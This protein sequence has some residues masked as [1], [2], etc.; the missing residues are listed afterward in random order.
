VLLLNRSAT[1]S[2]LIQ[3]AE[4]K[5]LYATAGIETNQT[6]PPED[7]TAGGRGVAWGGGGQDQIT[8]GGNAVTAVG[9][10]RVAATDTFSV[11]VRAQAVITVNAGLTAGD[12][13]TI[14][15][16]D[17]SAQASVTLTCVVGPRVPGSLTFDAAV[18]AAAQAVNI[19]TAINDSIISSP[20]GPQQIATSTVLL[21][22]VTLTAGVRVSLRGANG[23]APVRKNG[24]ATTSSLFPQVWVGTQL[25]ATTATAGALTLGQFT[26]GVNADGAQ[27]YDDNNAPGGPYY[28]R[29]ISYTQNIA[30]A[31]N[32]APGVAAD[33]TQVAYV[34]GPTAFDAVARVW[35]NPIGTAGNGIVLTENTAGARITVTSPTAGGVDAVPASIAAATSTVIPPGSAITLALGSEGN[36]QALGTDAYWGV[37]S[38]SGYGIIV[39]MEAGGPADL[40]VTYINNRGYPE[41]V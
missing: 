35:A 10:P 15:Y 40:N 14:A 32:D 4:L 12:T 38:G 25:T 23:N 33:V 16:G 22:T 28:N 1:E 27:P 26:G 34:T 6:F 17:G 24:D 13:I 11:D 2:M 37:N 39:Q 30:V 36:R 21:T 29:S 19:N 31:L 18:G 3:I 41:G 9:G 20:P 5:S 8:I 7:R